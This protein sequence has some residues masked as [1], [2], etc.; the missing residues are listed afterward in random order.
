MTYPDK[1]DVKRF[2]DIADVITG[3]TPSKKNT[4][5]YG[6]GI[7]FVTPSDLD[8]GKPVASSSNTLTELGVTKARLLPKGAVLV[9]CIGATIGKTGIA[10][11]ELTTNQQI[12]SL[13]CNRE[14]AHPE[15]VYQYVRTLKSSL[16]HISSSTTIPIVNKSRFKKIKVPLPPLPEQRRIAAILDKADELRTKRKAALDK[17]DALLE[18]IFLDMFGDPV[19]NPKGWDTKLMSELICEGPQNGLYRPASDYGNG[20]PI[21]RIDSFYAGKIT[22]LKD[23]KRV[24][25]PPKL[26]DKYR[27]HEN[28]ILINRVNSPEYLGKSAIIPSL[29][30]LTVFE[31]NMMR[32]GVNQKVILPHYLVALMQHDYIR[33]QILKCSKDA[34]NQSSINQTDIKSF[35]IRLPPLELQKEFIR[36]QSRFE[37]LRTQ[38]QS[39]LKIL[40]NLFHSLQQRA[41]RGEL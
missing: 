34:V 6:G 5:Y 24:N 31:S 39:M 22:R 21:I 28:D 3:T 15:Y 35:E 30:E 12:N 33:M 20:T 29:R 10:G 17:L 36:V 14:I 41:F 2:E 38:Q 25:I 40:D 19:T 1:W 9:C 18:S 16:K 8:S 37:N 23:L 32:L 4:E 27:V 7:P 11:T 26:Q 13:A